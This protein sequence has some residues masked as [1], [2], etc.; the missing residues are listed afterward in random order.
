M[1]KVLTGLVMV[2]AKNHLMAAESS[3]DGHIGELFWPAINF[4]VL[5]IF[6]TVKLIAVLRKTLEEES[7]NVKNLY[8]FAEKKDRETQIRL[9]IYR[10]KLAN[11]DAEKRKIGENTRQEIRAF[12]KSIERETQKIISKMKKEGNDKIN[13]EKMGMIAA[14]H[15]TLVEKIIV[16]TKQTALEDDLGS[17]VVKKLILRLE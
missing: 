10:K 5:L 7:V 15:S 14:I 16:K 6:L 8:D 2:L 11:F 3:G 4:G 13:N 9:E 17:G 12:Q 1:S